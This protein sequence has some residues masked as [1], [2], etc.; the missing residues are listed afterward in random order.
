MFVR[1][2]SSPFL[3]CLNLEGRRERK[4]GGRWVHFLRVAVK[5]K[6]YSNCRRGGWC[7]KER[8]RLLELAS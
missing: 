1:D 6:L 8:R 3:G 7:T 5:T 2:V 4:R